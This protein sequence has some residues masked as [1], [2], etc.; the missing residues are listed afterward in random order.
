MKKIIFLFL[1]AWINVNAQKELWGVN[2]GDYVNV[3]GFPFN[4]GKIVKFDINGENSEVM[5]DFDSIQGYRPLGRLFLASNGKLYGTAVVGGE[6]GPVVTIAN[7]GVLFEYDLILNKYRVVHYFGSDNI[8]Y[9]TP[10][11][12]VIEPTPGILCGAT[13]NRIYNYDIVT[14]SMTFSNPLLYQNI[15]TG[16]LMKASNGYIYGVSY[17]GYCQNITSPLP[18]LGNIIKY[19]IVTN[20]VSFAH[21]ITCPQRE[22]KGAGPRNQLVEASIGKLYGTC[23]SGGINE[24]NDPDNLKGGTLFEYNIDTDAYTKKID[25]DFPTIGAYPLNLVIGDNAKI[26]GICEEG[27]ASQSCD[28]TNNFGTLYEYTAD[29]NVLE[30]KQ[31]LNLCTTPIRYPQFLMRTSNGHFIGIA[32]DGNIFKYDAVTNVITYISTFYKP[33]NLIEICRKPSYH[34]FDVD[35]FTPCVNSPFTFDVQNTNASS[36]T[37]KKDGEI[38]PMQTTGVLTISNS[39]ASDSGNYTCEMVNECGTTVTMVL[40]VNVGCLGIDEMA[41]YNKL[42]TLYPNPAQDVMNIKLPENGNLKIEGYTISNMLGQ[43]VFISKDNN[44]RINTANFAAGLYNVVLQT[45]KGNWLGKF[46]KE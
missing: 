33:L 4:Y 1:L 24:F 31:Y 13:L 37:W 41:A 32:V 25:F 21:S 3:P 43:A 22:L 35:T 11:I 28:P 10:E 42:I 23:R 46:I 15:V 16:E 38:V 36:Y 18:Y 40:H 19:D 26:Y 8:G 17:G 12:G 30:V 27:G 45:D 6:T 14:E 20:N 5:H 7:A 39:T 29:T 2:D 34:F 44:A 9:T